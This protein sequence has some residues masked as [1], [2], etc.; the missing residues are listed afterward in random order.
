MVYA[1]TFTVGGFAR[2]ASMLYNSVW[3]FVMPALV[4]GIHVLPAATQQA[5]RGLAGT[6]PALTNAQLDTVDPKEIV[7]KF[8]RWR[9]EGRVKITIS[10]H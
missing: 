7:R 10:E 5:M 3:F 2:S 4:A 6:S 1:V 8:R 9:T